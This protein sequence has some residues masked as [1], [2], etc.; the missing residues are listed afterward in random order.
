MAIPC[1][2]T[3]FGYS[4]VV[5]VVVIT[6]FVGFYPPMRISEAGADLNPQENQ[7]SASVFTRSAAI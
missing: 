6:H 4:V 3:V 2:F 5:P 1:Y 7:P